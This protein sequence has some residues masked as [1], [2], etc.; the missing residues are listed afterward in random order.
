MIPITQTLILGLLTFLSIENMH[1]RP[2]PNKMFD[3]VP[4]ISKRKVSGFPLCLH[5]PPVSF[6]F[7]LET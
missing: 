5:I 6:D 2:P 1:R 3:A 4:D 7:T